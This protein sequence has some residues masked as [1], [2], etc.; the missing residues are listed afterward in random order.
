MDILT[1][2]FLFILY[3]AAVFWISGFF[4]KWQGKRLIEI[5]K[6]LYA[7]IIPSSFASGFAFLGAPLGFAEQGISFFAF[8]FGVILSV[9]FLPM[10]IE[11][12]APVVETYKIKDFVSFILCRYDKNKALKI[13]VL[14]TVIFLSV[15]YI[16]LNIRVLNFVFGIQTLFEKFFYMPFIFSALYVFIALQKDE[17]ELSSLSFQ[18]ILMFV[19]MIFVGLWFLLCPERVPSKAFIIV[20]DSLFREKLTL[21]HGDFLWWQSVMIFSAF[22]YFFLPR[23]FSLI[24]SGV[25][26][27]P[28][29]SFFKT[30]TVTIVFFLVFTFFFSLHF[31]GG[32]LE[33]LAE[34]R[35]HLKDVNWLLDFQIFLREKTSFLFSILFLFTGFAFIVSTLMKELNNLS[36]IVKEY[37]HQRRVFLIGFFLLSGFVL[38]FFIEELNLARLFIL[39]GIFIFQFFI[40]LAGGMLWKNGTSR[41][42]FAGLGIGLL[43]TL[44]LGGLNFLSDPASFYNHQP[45]LENSGFFLMDRNKIDYLMTAFLLSSFFN[46]SFYIAFSLTEYRKKSEVPF[47]YLGKK[48]EELKAQSFESILKVFDYDIDRVVILAVLFNNQKLSF[49]SAELKEY[50]GL[51]QIHNK[52]SLL[53]KQRFITEIEAP[54]GRSFQI[55]LKILKKYDFEDFFN[56]FYSFK[57]LF[58]KTSRRM[59]E[60]KKSIENQLNQLQ[61]IYKIYLRIISI[62][63]RKDFIKTIAKIL[64]MYYTS[65]LRIEMIRENKTSIVFIHPDF[66]SEKEHF[67]FKI[68]LN[69]QE[70]LNIAVSNESEIENFFVIEPVISLA[71]KLI[72]YIDKLKNYALR[73]KNIDTIRSYFIS[74]ISHELRTP[75]VPL[76]GYLSMLKKNADVEKNNDLQDMVNTMEISYNRLETLIENLLVFKEISFEYFKTEKVNILEIIFNVIMNLKEKIQRKNIQIDFQE[77]EFEKMVIE[78]DKDKIRLAF[79]QVIDNAVKFN[80]FDG[81]IRLKGMEKDDSV[82][83]K[84][85]DNG[86][87]MT[88]EVIKKAFSSFY[89]AEAD[90]NRRFEGVGLGLSLVKKVV[91]LHGGKTSIHSREGK[92]TIVYIKLPKTI[93]FPEADSID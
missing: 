69:N 12:L 16:A 26:K 70:F 27:Q 73:L 38:S 6:W 29:L 89:Q 2:Y 91:M 10:L 47:L 48:E 31:G 18:G 41:G 42:A 60:N 23:Q 30:G 33:Y 20:K 75:L 85:Y 5:K 79:Y 83:V 67:D 65:I 62:K 34:I 3:L 82:I 66:T 92:G 32:F 28:K 43:L 81:K 93:H 87:G 17:K 55:N 68:H 64:A 59:K 56:S 71:Y 74:N 49:T 78:G 76:K 50:L 63:K 57:Y 21:H 35:P 22:M 77:K 53:L 44:I 11:R 45:F 72:I 36:S 4:E 39:F 25:K 40:P 61:V 88:K 51:P 86:I 84:I 80:Q 58:D 37:F 19:F 1:G 15:F 24:L 9:L 90:V 13:L 46:F 54:E 52:I 14:G 7:V 8:P